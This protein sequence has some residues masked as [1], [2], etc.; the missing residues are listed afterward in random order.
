MAV[1]KNFTF[2]RGTR[3]HVHPTICT[4]PP[5]SSIAQ[6]I[7]PANPD[8]QKISRVESPLDHPKISIS[9]TDRSKA[10]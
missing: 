8:F 3:K 5:L 2:I 6:S 9:L 4:P 7:R 10:I 1:N